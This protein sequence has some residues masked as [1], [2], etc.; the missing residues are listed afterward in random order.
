MDKLEILGESAQWDICATDACMGRRGQGR[1]RAPADLPKWIYPAVR[2]DGKQ[3]LLMKVL[4]SNACQ[5][6]CAYCANRCGRAERSAGFGA[7]ELARTFLALHGRGL[8][9]G[10]F[11]SSAVPD[12]AN[13]TMER[14]LKAVEM[15]RIK[16][17][18]GGYIHLK[19]LPGAG[20]DR[21]QRAVQLADRVSINLEAPGPERLRQI[22]PD[23]D[24]EGDLLTRMRWIRDLI[25]RERSTCRGHT[26]QFIVG[27]A[28]EADQEILQTAGRLYAEMSLERC[29]FSAFAPVPGTPLED[30]RAA[31]LTRENR[32]YQADFLFRRYGW[33]PEELIFGADGNL[34]LGADPKLVWARAH[35]E[36]FPIE[37]NRADLHELLRIPGIGPTSARRILATRRK[38]RLTSLEDLRSLGAV[39]SRAAGYVLLAGRRPGREGGQLQMEFGG[40]SGE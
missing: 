2:P 20:F 37:V 8:A 10:L 5:N 30:A 6:A 29:Y 31:P 28:G 40:A 36:H 12:S 16:H 19:I 32:L 14:M 15:L 38:G 4:M 26:T 13:Q 33:R 3:V 9:R 34:A 27:A 22:A 23:K 25:A 39:A 1:R 24:F 17:R 35:S 7:D 11:L 21:I 18:F